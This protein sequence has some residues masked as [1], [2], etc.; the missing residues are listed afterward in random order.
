MKKII[1]FVLL[2]TCLS[3]KAQDTVYVNQTLPDS[4]ELVKLDI[5]VFEYTL[6]KCYCETEKRIFVEI[7]TVYI[8]IKRENIIMKND[9]F[10]YLTRKENYVRK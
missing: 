5:K 3:S 1:L 10:Y 4:I 7:D 9:K 6:I 2:F 8:E